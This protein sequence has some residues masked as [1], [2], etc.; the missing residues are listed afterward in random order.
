M[1]VASVKLARS[2]KVALEKPTPVKFALEKSVSRVKFAL[3]KLAIWAKFVPQNSAYP[4]KVAPENC[5]EAP[6]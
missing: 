5:N 1:K 4:E 3:E 6:K 2:A